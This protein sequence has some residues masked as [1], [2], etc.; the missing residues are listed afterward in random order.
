MNSNPL[1]V[2]LHI[3]RASMDLCVCADSAWDIESTT[4]TSTT[5]T[6]KDNDA[7]ADGAS[8]TGTE[9]RSYRLN[10]EEASFIGR[11]RMSAVSSWYNYRSNNN[12]YLS[13]CVS[14]YSTLLSMIAA[15]CLLHGINTHTHSL[16]TLF[17]SLSV[18]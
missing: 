7:I 11:E 17:S 13:I 8:N 16:S 18:R 5:S 10:T 12:V 1:P 14:R 2:P 9:Q 3:K 15:Y 4:S 6:D